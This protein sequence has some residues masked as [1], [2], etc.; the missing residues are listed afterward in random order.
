MR[1]K[2]VVICVVPRAS[3]SMI[4][5]SSLRMMPKSRVT[6]TAAGSPSSAVKGR[7]AWLT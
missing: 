1:V 4:R 6:P 7:Q 5:E 2:A 3:V